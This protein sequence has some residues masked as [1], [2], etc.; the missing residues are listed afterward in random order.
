MGKMKD[1]LYTGQAFSTKSDTDVTADSALLSA[2]R[3]DD[4][5]GD[6]ILMLSCCCCTV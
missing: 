5:N 2:M 4:G 1:Y 6:R 3:L